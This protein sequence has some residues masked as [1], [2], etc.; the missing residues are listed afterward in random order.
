MLSQKLLVDVG[1]GMF[2]GKNRYR[3][4]KSATKSAHTLL[5]ASWLSRQVLAII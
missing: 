1:I 2:G 4:H 5:S 3:R